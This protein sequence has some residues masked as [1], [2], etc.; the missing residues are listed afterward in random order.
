[1]NQPFGFSASGDD[2]PGDRPGDD[3]SGHRPGGQGGAGGPGGAGGFD[4]SQL[5]PGMAPEVRIAVTFPGPVTDADEE[6]TI[7]GNTASWTTLAAVAEGGYAT[8]ELNAGLFAGTGWLIWVV[9][10]LLL[11]GVLVVVLV[12]LAQ[13]KSRR[14]VAAADGDA[15]A[16]LA[17]PSAAPPPGQSQWHGHSDSPPG[18]GYWQ[19]QAPPSDQGYSHGPPPPGYGQSPP[20]Q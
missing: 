15:A 8:G 6:A 10:G 17:D 5:P 13:R 14:T 9:A 4:P 1:M 16:G 7:D 18:Q 20:P 12:L 2:D 19:G 3:G 11:A